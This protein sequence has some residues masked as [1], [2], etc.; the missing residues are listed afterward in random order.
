MTKKEAIKAL[1]KEPCED[2]VRREASIPKEWQ[3]WE[4]ILNT[5]EVDF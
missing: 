1:E 3:D 4:R 5:R 2:C